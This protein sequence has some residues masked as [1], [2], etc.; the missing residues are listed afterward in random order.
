MVRKVKVFG[1]TVEIFYKD[2]IDQSVKSMW[3]NE[4]KENIPFNQLKY[5]TINKELAK[6]L[7]EDSYRVRIDFIM[8]L[9]CKIAGEYLKSIGM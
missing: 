5:K 6:K 9:S 2:G 7:D 3:R 8:G 1:K 4:N